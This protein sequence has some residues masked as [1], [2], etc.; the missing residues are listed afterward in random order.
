M[1]AIYLDFHHRLQERAIVTPFNE[2]V[3]E[4]NEFFLSHMPGLEKSY[5]S[6]DCIA[7]ESKSN[8]ENELFYLTEVLNGL[9]YPGIPNHEVKLKVGYVIML[10]RNIS[11][12]NGLC[13]A[14]GLIVTQLSSYVIKSR[15]TSGSNIGQKIFHFKNSNEYQ[16]TKYLFCNE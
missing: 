10:M 5:Y 9:T 16:R 3:N 14:T 15:I 13:N 11:Q 8:L 12:T 1:N 2:N 7:M 6:L 4:L